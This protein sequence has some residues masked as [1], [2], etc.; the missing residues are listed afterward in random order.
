VQRYA[1]T[2]IILALLAA[3]AVAFVTT[4]RQKLEPSPVGRIAVDPVFS[5][6]CRCDKR[7]ASIVIGLRRTDTVTLELVS[8][9]GTPVRTL[10]DRE[11]YKA[12]SAVSVEWDGYGGPPAR[13]F[14]PGVH[15]AGPALPQ[16]DDRAVVEV[17]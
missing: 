2:A 4:Q 15:P 14:V 17:G 11:R 10:V 1:P 5:P 6:V 7:T 3:T 12:K 13:R 8:S 16:V 9:T